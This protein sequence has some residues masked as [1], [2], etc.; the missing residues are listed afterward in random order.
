MSYKQENSKG[1]TY[2]LNATK[3]VLK[4]GKEQTIYYFSKDFRKATAVD[5]PENK[6]VVETGANGFLLLKNK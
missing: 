3:T 5:L 2:Y 4:N 1:V 6:E